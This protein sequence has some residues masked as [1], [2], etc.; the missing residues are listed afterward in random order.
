MGPTRPARD[1]TGVTSVAFT[2]VMGA[3]VAVVALVVHVGL[4]YHVALAVDDA[5]DAALE[6]AQ[7]ARPADPAAAARHVVGGD[8]NVADLTVAVTRGTDTVTVVVTA[9]APRIAPGL[10]RQVT[11]TAVGPVERFIPQP[12]R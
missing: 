1:D 3:V 4:L 8:A 9:T 7:G 6:A 5:A 2:L 10:P 12:E 11:R